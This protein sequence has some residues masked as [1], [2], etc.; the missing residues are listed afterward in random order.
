[1][2]KSI[3]LLGF[4]VVITITSCGQKVDNEINTPTETDFKAELLVS[5]LQIPWGMEFLPD[6]G[7]LITEKSGEIILFKDGQKTLIENV[8]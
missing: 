4:F 8:P 3:A 2:K 6:G 5:D 1:M 7:M